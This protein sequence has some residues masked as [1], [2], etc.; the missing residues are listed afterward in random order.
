MN[1]TKKCPAEKLDAVKNYVLSCIEDYHGGNEE[2]ISFIMQIFN[3]EYWYQ[4]NQQRYNGDTTKALKNYLQGLPSCIDTAFYPDEIQELLTEW[5][6]LTA[7]ASE[8]TL[9]KELEN[10][11]T[12]LAKAI[13][14]LD[15]QFKS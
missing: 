6:Y 12:Y 10:Y 13:V 15:T 1:N 4:Y 14:S 11:W 5:G 2:K 3:D 8:D 7:D 9:E